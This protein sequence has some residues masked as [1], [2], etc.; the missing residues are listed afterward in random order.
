M[1]VLQ[2]HVENKLKENLNPIFLKVEDFSDGC[3][4]KYNVFVVSKDFEGKGLLQRQRLVNEILKEE[5]SEI[6]ALTQKCVT[7]EQW[8]KMVAENP[9]LSNENQVEKPNDST[10]KCEFHQ[11]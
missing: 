1:P 9:N 3:G 2:S 11:H 10:K 6:H 8:E 7:P 4:F 5:M